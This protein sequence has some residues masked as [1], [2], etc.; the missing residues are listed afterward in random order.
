MKIRYL[1]IPLGVFLLSGCC[2]FNYSAEVKEVLIPMQEELSS[3]Y[4]KNKRYP[5]IKERNEILDKLGCKVFNNKCKYSGNKFNITS[6]IFI[7]KYKIGLEKGSSRC[8]T[9][10]LKNGQKDD[11]S[12]YQDGCYKLDH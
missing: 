1:V 3:F 2:A 5:N 9:G 4:T 6:E 12:C 7:G 11:L 10:L 8:Y